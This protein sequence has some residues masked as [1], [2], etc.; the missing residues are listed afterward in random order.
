M[1]ERW[2]G[3]ARRT[4]FFARD[5]AGNCGSP[6]IETEHLL[7]GIF[8]Q[9][10][11]LLQRV[12][13][14]LSVDAVREAGTRPGAKIPRNLD[15]PVSDDLKRAFEYADEEAARLADKQIQ[16]E[17]LLLALMRIERSTA[18]KLLRD[19]GANVQGM[20]VGMSESAGTAPFYCPTCAQAVSDPLTCG[21][22]S[23]V[24][25]R[26]CGTPLESASDLGM[27]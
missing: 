24:I 27:G 8:R 13:P 7:L 18:A 9:E 15:L 23:A 5:E 4:I 16:P 11:Q 21:D 26:R 3:S 19:A 20:R 22:C 6:Y 14:K 25:C 10:P 12:A 1:F 2:T 17:H